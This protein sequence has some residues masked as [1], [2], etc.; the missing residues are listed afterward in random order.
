[1]MIVISIINNRFEITNY[2]RLLHH[3]GLSNT[4]LVQLNCVVHKSLGYIAKMN[5]CN[6]N[7][8][9]FVTDRTHILFKM[10]I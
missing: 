5:I 1:M 3:I 2:E 7:I 6:S 4:S 9:S 8:L 10:K